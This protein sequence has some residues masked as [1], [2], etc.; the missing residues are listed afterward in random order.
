[1]PNSHDN[2]IGPGDGLDLLGKCGHGQRVVAHGVK[3][4]WQASEKAHTGVLNRGD[5]PM[6]RLPGVT[7]LT[8]EEMADSLVAKADTEHG[9]TALKDRA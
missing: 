7:D 6:H 8:A 9:Q 5:T 4:R 2:V 1:M 3:R